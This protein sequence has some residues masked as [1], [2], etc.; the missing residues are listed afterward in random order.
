M[1]MAILLLVPSLPLVSTF[2]YDPYIHSRLDVIETWRDPSGGGEDLK[3]R[4][5]KDGTRLLMQGYGAP[6][7]VRVTDMDTG[8][9]TVLEPPGPDFKV[10]GCDWSMAEDQIVVWGGSTEGPLIVVY[11]VPSYLPN[12]TVKWPGIV[13]LVQVTEV[14]YLADDIIISV[15]GRDANGTSR[16]LF[17]E[18]EPVSVRRD[19]VWEGNHTI[20]EVGDEGGELVIMDTGNTITVQN[21]S[22]WSTFTRFP[23]ALHAGPASWHVPIGHPWG[24]GDAGGRVV[25]ALGFPYLPEGTIT[26]SSGPVT[27]FAWTL[28]RTY[29]FVV[30]SDL[31]GGGSRLAGWEVISEDSN[32]VAPTELCSLEIE[33]HVTMMLPDPRGWSSVLVALDDGTLMSVQFDV[34]P[35]PIVV[36]PWA[37]DMVDGHG[38]E[39]F[40]SWFPGGTSQEHRFYLNNQGSLIA[41]RGFGAQGDLRVVD[42]TFATVAELNVP[43][44]PV[45]FGGLEWSNSDSWLLVWGFQGTVDDPKMVLRAYDAPDFT[46][47]TNLDVDMITNVAFLVWSM[48][49]LPGDRSLVM[50]GVDW[51][52]ELVIITLDLTNG[53]VISKVPMIGDVFMDLVPDGDDLVA[54]SELGSVWRLSPPDWDPVLVIAGSGSMLAGWDINGSSGWSIIAPDYNISVWNGTPRE[55]VIRWRI[56]PQ[57]PGDLA[58]ANGNEGDLVLGHRRQWGGSSIQLWRPGRH[59]DAEWRFRDGL[60]MMT[61]INTS[62]HLVQMEADP[63]F[64]GIVLVSFEDGTIAL[65]HLNLTPYPPPPEE[66]TGLNIGP[67]YPVETDDGTGNGG[68]DPP[69]GSS[70]DW[71][72]PVLLVLG[73]GALLAL[74]VVLRKMGGREEED[75]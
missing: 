26:V 16:L 29:D 69:W 59:G 5:S 22:D 1:V 19:H 3:I 36:E 55:E 15:A 38:I 46:K 68:V 14:S 45:R 65:Y 63:A 41:L 32:D 57:D 20:I 61:E 28:S 37:P 50:A 8:N 9:A 6:G 27:G 74:L 40:L 10:V 52:G 24:I 62:R 72:L 2:P 49:F 64:P 39:P 47:S 58:W 11:D 31:P 13:D 17:L 23:D 21:S 44:D 4:I 71:L 7:E 53:E 54:V 48:E 75:G 30:A 56:F 43:W 60:T 33:G 66:L 12:S 25:L 34:R 35:N 70:T 51:D 73:I 67:I 42:R 18:V